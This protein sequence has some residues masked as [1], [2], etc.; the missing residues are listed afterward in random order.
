MLD[1]NTPVVDKHTCC[2]QTHMLD[3]N[4]PVVDKH[5]C[6]TQTHLKRVKIKKGPQI[7][8]HCGPF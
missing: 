3:A 2:R 8:I 5:T 7:K 6:S 4:T 1:V